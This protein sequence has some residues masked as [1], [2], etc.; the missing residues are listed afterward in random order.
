MD[1]AVYPTDIGNVYIEGRRKKVTLSLH[2]YPFAGNVTLTDAVL[3]FLYSLP[4]EEDATTTFS[5][6]GG[7][8]NRRVYPGPS[9]FV[10]R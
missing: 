5:L 2:H 9:L 10:T 3:Q 6:P 1:R 4:G 8:F 7:A